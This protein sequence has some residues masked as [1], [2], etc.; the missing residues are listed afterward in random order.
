MLRRLFAS[1]LVL[2][3]AAAPAQAL[4]IVINNLDG[5]GEGFNDPT[6]A[7]PVGGNSGTT[8][9]AQRL[10]VFQTA[11]DIWESVLDGPDADNV[12]IEVDANFDVLTCSATSAV[13]GSAGAVWIDR[14]FPEAEFSGSWYHGAL[15][16]RLANEDRDTFSSEISARFNSALNGQASCLGG[17]G[18]YLGLDGNEGGD[19]EL[20]PV[21]LH[22]IG[23]G[24]GFST[25]VNEATGELFNGRNDMFGRYLYD[26]T[27]DLRWGP[28]SNAQRA[29]SAV[30]TGN[31]VWF[32]DTVNDAAPSLLNPAAALSVTAPPS[33]AGTIT[34]V[35]EASFGPTATAA[36]FSGQLVLIDDGVGTTS[37]GCTAAVNGAALS[38]NVA[39][40]DRGDC[41]FTDKVLNAQAAG[42]VGVIIV[43]NV[44]G[45]QTVA[46]GG[47]DPG[48]INIATLSVSLEQGNILKSELGNGV[49]VEFALTPGVFAGINP[50]NGRVRMYA[51][52]PLEQGSSVSH[53]DTAAEPSLLMEPAITGGLSS[54]VDLTRELFEDMGWFPVA[55]DTGSV[56][57]VSST[58]LKGNWPNPFNPNTKIAFDLARAGT[59]ELAVFDAS[60]RRV[61]TLVDGVRAAGPYEVQWNGTDETG[62]TVASGVYR[63][64]LEADGVTSTRSMVLLK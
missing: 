40:I 51:P 50:Q 1:A 45:N 23:H 55:S 26:E 12:V 36:P 16:N 31:L 44:A 38:G 48:T 54:D 6:P 34:E 5:A 64:V 57:T 59:V 33:I 22:E 9:G 7:T 41:N 10:I 20:L 46:M 39:L 21:V 28:M 29:A 60:G 49:F 35:G 2:T 18:W 37:D 13:L 25:F 14:G 43:N 47:T 42:A 27:V 52:N 4:E 17:R 32:G 3:L 56:P 30:N 15:V 24:L 8:L 61:K 19:I 58:R 62:R 11:A 53:F 63:A